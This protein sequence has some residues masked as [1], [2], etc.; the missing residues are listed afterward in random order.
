MTRHCYS[1]S[2]ARDQILT[3][4]AKAFFALAYADFVEHLDAENPD[5]DPDDYDRPGPGGDWMDYL[6]S[7]PGQ[8]WAL[9]GQLWEAI[10]RDNP[11]P[12]GMFRVIIEMDALEPDFDREDF[13]FC[14]AMQAMGTGVRWSDSHPDHGLKLPYWEVSS[15]TFAPDAY[16]EGG[17]GRMSHDLCFQTSISRGFDAGNYANA[18]ETQDLES[19]L[20]MSNADEQSPEFRSAF[21]LGF[22]A[23]YELDEIPSSN[24]EEFDDAYWS[25]AGKAVVAAGYCD[26]REDEYKQEQE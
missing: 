17:V 20:E 7:L 16:K 4:M 25:E 26:S 8:A 5:L 1:D 23:S 10:E 22:F 2:E 14:L 11:K 21:I 18:Y 13:G 15:F 3:G 9:A 19:A 6:P 24:R 12:A